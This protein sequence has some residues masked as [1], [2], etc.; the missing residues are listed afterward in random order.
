[1]AQLHSASHEVVQYSH[2]LLLDLLVWNGIPVGLLACVAL[3]AWFVWQVRLAQSA[4]RVL[5]LLAVA[6]L[7]VHS[8][9]ELPHGYA[10]FL[11]P[12]GLM[13]GA[14][15]VA[16]MR[17]RELAVPRAAMAMPLAAFLICLV[18]VIKDYLRI[19]D[20]WMAH[21]FRTAR[22]GSMAVE[23]VPDAALLTNLRALLEF[24]RIEP[25][26]RMSEEDIEK[27]RLV[28]RRQPSAGGLFRYAQAVALNG[29][30]PEASATLDRLAPL[31][32]LK[33][34]ASAPGKRGCR[35][36]AQASRKCLQR[37]PPS[38]ESCAPGQKQGQE[39]IPDQ[40]DRFAEFLLICSR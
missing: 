2:N 34:C 38:I 13:I 9:L 8:M 23:P 3:V 5:L 1:M 11:L 20:A 29:N 4:E 12:A 21:R 19:E 24:M 14:L 39:A 36:A 26:R 7:L 28:A 18:L 30:I 40:H 17:H 37:G 27:L 33:L 25:R 35:S 22:I 6:A 15:H 10:L 32:I 31:F 16:P